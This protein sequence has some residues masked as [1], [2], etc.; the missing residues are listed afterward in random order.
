[1]LSS[2]SSVLDSI[3]IFA[4]VL[5]QGKL[6]TRM[7][8]HKLVDS[9]QQVDSVIINLWNKFCTA[10]QEVSNTSF[11]RRSFNTDF[12]VKLL[13][14]ADASKEAYGCAI[15]AAQGKATSLIFSKV[16][17]SPLKERSLPT[18]EL[19]GAQLALKCFST[20]FENGLFN[21]TKVDSITLFVGSQVC[22]SWILSNKAPKKNMCVNN[23]LSE[24][25][26]II[27]H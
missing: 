11:A 15:Y 17:V 16:K 20:I 1:M 12:P 6:I 14:F 2:L 13:L 18:L 27:C 22:L 9:D 5:L 25:E 10:F 23:R 4:P 3:C 8:C 19:L 21:G 7:L 26:S 24:T